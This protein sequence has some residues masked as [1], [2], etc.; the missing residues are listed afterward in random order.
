MRF[1]NIGPAG[2]WGTDAGFML[3]DVGAMRRE[4]MKGRHPSWLVQAGNGY[5]DDIGEAMIGVQPQT[6][7][8]S[9]ASG[10]ARKLPPVQERRWQGTEG[11][12]LYIAI[13]QSQAG[14]R[15]STESHRLVPSNGGWGQEQRVLSCG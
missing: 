12:E 4:P 5:R 13:L 15:Y 6:P 14:L 9:N 3:D 2:T 7:A 10:I 1:K 11:A 8:R